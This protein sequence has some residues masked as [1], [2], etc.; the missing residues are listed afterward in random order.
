MTLKHPQCFS[1]QPTDVSRIAPAGS[2]S[3]DFP[4]SRLT[5]VEQQIPLDGFKPT[6]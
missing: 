3:V 4:K 1:P 2:E 5:H 6:L